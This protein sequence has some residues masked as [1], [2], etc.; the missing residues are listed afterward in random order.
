MENSCFTIGRAAWSNENPFI[1]ELLK[2]D[3]RLLGDASQFLKAVSSADLD[4][5]HLWQIHT[6]KLLTENNL[7]ANADI[8]ATIDY[9]RLRTI[10][11]SVSTSDWV[12]VSEK[13]ERLADSYRR[14][15]RYSACIYMLAAKVLIEHVT[16]QKTIDK[17]LRSR[18]S[19]HAHE[20]LL[21]A[22]GIWPDSENAQECRELLNRIEKRKLSI[23]F[24]RIERA[25]VPNLAMLTYTNIDTVW[26]KAIRYDKSSYSDLRTNLYRNDFITM[27]QDGSIPD[28]HVAASWSVATAQVNRNDWIEHSMWVSLPALEKGEY[29][30]V[31][32]PDRNVTY[33]QQDIVYAHISYRF[34]Q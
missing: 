15:S 9:K 20:L 17:E 11:E 10:V 27:I 12:S 25:G 13:I 1:T 23:S 28:T 3:K 2:S 34:R 21:D 4:N 8:R 24:D 18:L 29:I 22:I 14:K 16:D 26:F 31:A 5:I 33:K 7:R 6:L 30:I 32:S 19:V